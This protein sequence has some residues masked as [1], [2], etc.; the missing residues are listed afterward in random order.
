MKSGLT[1]SEMRLVSRRD[2]PDR[3]RPRNGLPTINRRCSTSETLIEVAK[4]RLLV[5][6][7]GRQ[8]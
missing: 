3:V 8:A 2:K 1:P 4:I 5:A 6:R 7:R